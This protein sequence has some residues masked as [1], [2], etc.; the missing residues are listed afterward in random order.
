MCKLMEN[1][2]LWRFKSGWERETITG[3]KVRG[4]E[5]GENARR[6]AAASQRSVEI[7][8]EYRKRLELEPDTKRESIKA[9]LVDRFHCSRSTV[10]RAL[11]SKKRCHTGA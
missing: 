3:L 1:L 9:A 11:R 4:G 10:D 5:A 7:R 8:A 2:D 6:K